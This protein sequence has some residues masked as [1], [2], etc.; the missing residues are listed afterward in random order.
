MDCE[1]HSSWTMSNLANEFHENT[2]AD[3]NDKLLEKIEPFSLACWL[4]ECQVYTWPMEYLKV[5]ITEH[6][7]HLV[8]TVTA[9]A[10]PSQR[11]TLST[12]QAA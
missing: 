7:T 8:L 3:A 1:R 6:P 9:A 10:H 11:Q 12:I 2:I 5:S 4:D